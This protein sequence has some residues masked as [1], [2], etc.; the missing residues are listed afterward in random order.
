MQAHELANLFPM[1]T[2]G[3]H[4]ELLKDMRENGYDATAPIVIYEG[5]ILDG[6]NRWKAAQELG[7]V[8]TRIDYK[9]DDP[10]G[11]VIRHNLTRRHLNE[12]QRAVVA[13]RLA[14]M[15]SGERTDLVSIG[16][17]S[18]SIEQA[19]DMLNVGR[20]T[21]ARVKAV[22]RDAPELISA[23]EN[24]TISGHDASKIAKAEPVV[25]REAVAMVQRGEVRT[26][27]DAV[28][29][30]K[31]QERK[32][33]QKENNE[34]LSSQDVPMP[35]RKYGVIY[36]DPP[37]RYEFSSTSNRDIENH[38]PTMTLEEICALEVPKSDECVLFLWAT[39]P[40]LKEALEVIQA[41][42][43]EYVTNMVWVK[44]KIGMGYYARQR[45]ELLLIA[46]R[47]TPPVPEPSTRPDSVI[48]Y[49]RGEHSR[50]PSE[51]YELIEKMYPNMAKIELFSRTPQ[52]GWA[53]WGYE[54][55][56]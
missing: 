42:G 16:T 29:V 24:G 8:P 23:I 14:T 9:G 22:E 41:W 12:S 11:F 33:K 34:R 25:R 21:V 50:K 26:A 4:T 5:K 54:A 49:P 15:K 35:Q 36:A 53:V 32:E 48:Q 19:A 2:A 13:G 1:M 17:R 30:I 3:E 56:E 44:D 10:L 52:K 7:I 37:W 45:H 38:Y 47:G 46:K 27:Q 40:K 18:I 6:R 51:V 39:S 43:F 20:A 55:H 31:T 28:K